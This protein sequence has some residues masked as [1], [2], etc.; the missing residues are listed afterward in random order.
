[1]THIKILLA[2]LITAL[3]SVQLLADTS[4]E[5]ADQKYPTIL[6]I[7]VK[8]SGSTYSFTVTI[9]STYD[10]PERYADGFRVL[11]AEGQELGLRVL[12]HDHASEQPFSRSLTDVKIPNG[13]KV[14]FVEAR[15]KSYGWSGLLEEVMLP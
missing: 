8:Y 7:S 13:V 6:D 1:M 5:T 11:D 12:W 10:T 3:F 14:V 4:T 15:D 2:L 9:S